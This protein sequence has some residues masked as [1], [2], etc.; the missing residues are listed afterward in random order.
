MPGVP[1]DAPWSKEYAQTRKSE[2][3]YPDR[4]S[5][6]IPAH[7]QA[8]TRFGITHVQD[9]I[10]TIFLQILEALNIG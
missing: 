3:L 5:G 8:F 2:K 1:R 4:H 10:E 9:E 7:Y 6:R